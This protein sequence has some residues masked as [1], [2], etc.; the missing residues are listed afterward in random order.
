[1]R[2]DR[3]ERLQHPDLELNERRD[4]D[5][6]E[7]LDLFAD[8]LEHVCEDDVHCLARRTVRVEETDQLLESAEQNLIRPGVELEEILQVVFEDVGLLVRG[9][10]RALPIRSELLRRVRLRGPLERV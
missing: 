9:Q 6:N 3:D 5:R 8:V 2:L 7:L 10:E 1:E 4:D